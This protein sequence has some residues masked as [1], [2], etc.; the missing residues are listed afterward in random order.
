MKKVTQE[1][2]WSVIGPQNVTPYPVG[3]YPYTSTFKTPRGEIRGRIVDGANYFLAEDE[4][5]ICPACGGSGSEVGADGE[6]EHCHLCYKSPYK[7][8]F[9]KNS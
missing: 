9:T 2:F 8:I 4:E 5:E 3:D 7:Q 1:V 6:Y